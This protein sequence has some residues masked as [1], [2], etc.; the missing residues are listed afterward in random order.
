MIKY[1]VPEEQKEEALISLQNRIK[2]NNIGEILQFCVKSANALKK[3]QHNLDSEDV[4][5][6]ENTIGKG[7]N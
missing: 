5:Y 7:E 6:F 1:T 4:E 2:S 3:V